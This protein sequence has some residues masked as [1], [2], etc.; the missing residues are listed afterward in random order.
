MLKSLKIKNIALIKETKID[1]NEGFH[2]LTG[3]TGAGKTS[4]IH[5]FAL[6]LGMKADTAL[7]RDREK[8]AFVEAIFDIANNSSVKKILDDSGIII[9]EDDCLVIK[10][11]LD[12]NKKNGCFLNNQAISLS[13]L[14]EISSHLV[15]N[16]GSSEHTSLRLTETQ[17]SYI[18]LFLDNKELLLSFETAF[19]ALKQTK[20]EYNKISS[21]L[22]SKD[23]EISF[24]QNELL[25][26]EEVHPFEGEDEELEKEYNDLQSKLDSK[27]LLEEL[28]R[29]VETILSEHKSMETKID[30][31]KRGNAA[32]TSLEEHNKNALIEY[33]EID[34]LLRDFMIHEEELEGRL[35]YIEERL[36]KVDRLL[37]RFGGS[38]DTYIERKKE[39]EN[40]LGV[41]LTLDDQMNVLKER[42]QEKEALANLL[43]DRLTQE[44]KKAAQFFE[45]AVLSHL[46]ELNMPH[47]KLD[48]TFT[49]TPLSA[50]GK[51]SLTFLFSASKGSL[52]L[53]MEK[54]ASSGELSRLLFV[55]K[56]VLADKEK[57]PLMIFDEIDANIGGTTA[58]LV[59]EKLKLIA[60]TRQVFAITHFPQVARK[61]DRHFQV[62]KE[63]NE[64]ISYCTI[65]PLTKEEKKREILRMLGGENLSIL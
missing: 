8:N 36:S 38:Y 1:F 11:T 27:I 50:N 10:R 33:K 30:R 46:K 7:I 35:L 58:S 31:L 55:I 64:A 12:Q 24:L 59:G 43:A 44:R 40:R 61:A 52:P 28:S 6:T 25:Q 51:D 22:Q 20:E 26:M 32:F 53:P 14:Q 54:V 45:I 16:I 2:V 17:R 13:L 60:K 29:H 39:I 49:E 15:E 65:K 48:I 9:E 63:E 47:A 4:F 5:A 21:L 18:D 62:E 37:K 41:L 23:Y 42:L 57:V 19:L 34:Y 3:E 56:I